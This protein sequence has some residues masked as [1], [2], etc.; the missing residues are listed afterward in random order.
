MPPGDAERPGGVA[1]ERRDSFA[2]R[3]SSAWT[4]V[5]PGALEHH[6]E[7]HHEEDMPRVSITRRGALAFALFALVAIAFLYFVLPQL[8]GIKDTWNRLNDGDPW[9][10]AVAG[11]CELISMFAYIA[12]FQGVHVPPGSPI[13]YRESYQ[14]TMASLVATR[15]F[16]AG[17]AGGVA[18]TA[19]A[20][21]R[22]GMPRREVAQRMIAFLV[23]LYGVYMAAMVVCGFGLWF[24]LFP[25]P[26]PVAL[27]IVSA[28]FALVVIVLFLAIA[29]VPEDLERRLGE[30]GSR[31]H[32]V[33]RLIRK[34]ATGPASLSAGVRFAI[35][36][37]RHP[38]LALLGTVG[39]WAFNIAVLDAAFRAFGSAPPLAVLV[40]AY[41]VGML[42]NLLPLPG[43]IGGVDGGMIGALVAFGVS[44][45][46]ALVAVLAYRLFAFWLPTIPGTVAYFQ[47]RRTVSRWQG[48][49]AKIGGAEPATA[50]V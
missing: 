50:N 7:S 17:G 35:Y 28:I 14:I 38:D 45:S 36:K 12:L 49:D 34:L 25:G 20:L 40:Q 41:F 32:A 29:L 15:L 19:W 48:R 13:T 22:S 8:S 33:S 11:A 4:A 10:L 6:G 27:T 16:A 31:G 21:R 26:A 23:L 2:G 46:L 43:G 3:V 18:L 47:L 42:A 30:A 5:S 39:W 9:W 44:G 1:D 37:L 24:G